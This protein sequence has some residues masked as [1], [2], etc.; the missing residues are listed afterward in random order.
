MTAAFV[1]TQNF[2][3]GFAKFQAAVGGDD[4]FKQYVREGMRLMAEKLYGWTAPPTDGNKGSRG[5]RAGGKAMVDMSAAHIFAVREQEYIE[6]LQNR[7]GGSTIA[8]GTINKERGNTFSN[9]VLNPSG[10]LSA[11]QAYHNGR[12]NHRTGRTYAT[13]PTYDRKGANVHDRMIVTAK[14]LKRH[15]DAQKKLVGKL[16]AGWTEALKATGSTKYPPAWVK[17]A[18]G[19][20]GMSGTASGQSEDRID[21]MNWSGHWDAVNSTGYIR[22]PDGFVKRAADH[23][24]R[25]YLKGGKPLEG[26]LDRMIKKHSQ[27]QA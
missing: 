26:F 9:V 14:A 8:S 16:K 2:K 23:V 10:D 4:A 19:L 12:R 21:Y 15:T 7:F 24:E 6:S 1:M 17:T 3:D 25:F 11:M 22:D 20:P 18:G 5:G 13:R 27:V